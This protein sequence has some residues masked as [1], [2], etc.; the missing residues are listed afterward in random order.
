M[1]TVRTVLI[2]ENDPATL[3]MYQRV[4]EQEYEVLPASNEDEVLSLLN[5]HTVHAIVLEPGPLGGLGWELLAEM[6]RQSDQ[7]SIPIILCTAQD[8]KRRGLELGTAAYLVKPVL[9][10]A[11]LEMVRRLTGPGSSPGGVV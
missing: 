2:L 11:L 1:T 6:K 5:A 4:L 8:E 3:W 10:A 7:Q 9:P